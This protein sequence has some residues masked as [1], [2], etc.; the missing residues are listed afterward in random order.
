MVKWCEDARD[1]FIVVQNWFD[2]LERLAPPG[3]NQ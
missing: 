3:R 2:E 1:Q